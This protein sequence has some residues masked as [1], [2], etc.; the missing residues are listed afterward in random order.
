MATRWPPSREGELATYVAAVSVQLTAT[1]TLFGLVA[2]DA[3]NFAA[4]S[5][6]YV[7]A[8]TTATAPATRNTSTIAAKDLAK[9]NVLALLRSDAK[10]INA[11]PT[12]TAAAKGLI[13]LPI[14]DASPT[15]LP[16]PGTRPVLTLVG[17]GPRSQTVKIADEL[18]PDK[19]A[20]PFGV[21]GAELF[22]F[23]GT[24]APPSDVRQWTYLGQFT[25]NQA[26]IEWSAADVGKTP[27]LAARWFNDKAEYG[28]L[29]F[30]I[31]APIAG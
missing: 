8:Y 1:P 28:G 11:N 26:E 22:A 17:I 19:K 29:S 13:G 7:S 4:V 30:P 25:K 6:A 21:S 3:T 14:R 12:V 20:H 18:T 15:P 9:L 16:P 5:S 10:R 31:T 2:L 24:G 23:F 27:V